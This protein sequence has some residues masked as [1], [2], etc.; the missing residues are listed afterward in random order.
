MSSIF[1][2][3]ETLNPNLRTTYFKI[4]NYLEYIG[5]S[6]YAIRNENTS[7]GLFGTINQF[8][9]IQ[10]EEDIEPIKNHI[11]QLAKNKVPI[12]RGLISLKEIDASRLGFYEQEKWKTILENRLPSIAEKLNVKYE[13]LQYVGAVHI[14]KRTSTFSIYDMG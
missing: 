8:P 9:N 4:K 7:H 3:L 6:K 11:T 1:F 2:E 12:F 13:N 5:T 10:T 14:E